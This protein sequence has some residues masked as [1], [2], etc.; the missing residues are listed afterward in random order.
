MP[1]PFVVSTL[2]LQLAQITLLESRIP[3]HNKLN[4]EGILSCNDY[5]ANITIFYGTYLFHTSFAHFSIELEISIITLH[6]MFIEYFLDSTLFHFH[7]LYTHLFI[8][9][10]CI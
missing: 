9:N 7:V 4:F 8:P 6:V 3:L 1:K 10:H 5:P 2:L